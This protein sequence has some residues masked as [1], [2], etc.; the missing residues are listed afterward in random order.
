MITPTPLALAA[1]FFA[2]AP[3]LVA[4][5][6]G[7][8]STDAGRDGTDDER[9]DATASDGPK[10]ATRDAAD[11]ARTTDG[12]APL[13]TA[14][15][16]SSPVATMDGSAPITLVP[17]FSPSVYDYYVRCSEGAN[18]LAVTMTASDGSESLLVQPTVSPSRPTQTVSLTLNENEAMVAAATNRTATN[19]YWVRCLPHDF[20][21]LR[22][23]LHAEAGVPSPGYYLVGNSWL[24]AGETGGY[25][26]VL[27]RDGVPVWYARETGF[28]VFDVDDVVSGAV[29]FR[30]SSTGENFFVDEPFEIHQLSPSATL[31]VEPAGYLADE[32]ELRALSNGNFLVLSYP[33]K[34]GVDLTGLSLPLPDGGAQPL[35]PSS[36]IQ[37]C[38]VVELEPS[39]LVVWT[40]AASDH[41]DPSKDTTVVATGLGY[42]QGSD[43]GVVYDVF[44]CNSIDVDPSNGD[45]LLSARYMDS[46]FYVDRLTGSVLWKMGGATL[47]KDNATY[48]SV[49]DPFFR[50]HDARLL[51]G[52]S[53]TCSGGTGRISMFDDQSQGPGPARGVVYDV[54]VGLADGGT[55]AEGGCGDGGVLE[56]GAP[57]AASVTW[58]YKGSTS[59]GGAGSFRI[60]ADGS[61][62]IGWGFGGAPH[63]VFSEV[64]VGGNDRLDFEFTDNNESYRAIKVP[65][66][67]LDLKA[68]RYSAGLP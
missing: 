54:I 20:P 50:Q 59:S 35:G 37:D 68:M 45:L 13:L 17:P 28:G 36:V 5:S 31:D 14:L 56:G 52:W 67:A 6:S 29:S 21:Q 30:S 65:L 60:S 27:N 19:E 55:P 10:E 2:M 43:A 64:D 3:S 48:V 18:T 61:R 1:A 58:E 53:P 66:T 62:V 23:N 24:Q 22:M 40:W 8:R 4:C 7:A 26:I 42:G 33:S 46:V 38:V 11:S 41:F 51:P 34:S 9:R 49:A 63:L 47:T 44:H 25:A 39:G 12:G 32:H 16:V 15:A 57:G